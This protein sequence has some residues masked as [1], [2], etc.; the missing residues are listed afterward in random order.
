MILK[1]NESNSYF[2]TKE[3]VTTLKE[4]C[5]E[6]SDEDIHYQMEPS[7]DIRIKMLGLYLH[8]I[9]E[10][11]Y[12]PIEKFYVKT[13]YSK[14]PDKQK[15]IID[16]LTHLEFFIKSQ[17]LKF[18]YELYF[19]KIPLPEWTPKQNHLSRYL[20][21]DKIDERIFDSKNPVEQI[22]IIFSK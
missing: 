15:T 22:K 17:G 13:F 19:N 8:D 1:F 5:Q 16:T 3:I 9:L 2:E 14:D 18:Y 12:L 7:N 20:K 6:L 11:P 10:T 4:I 21:I